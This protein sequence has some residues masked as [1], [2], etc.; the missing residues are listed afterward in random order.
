[1][2]SPTSL[3]RL[4]RR[5]GHAASGSATTTRTLSFN[6]HSER[7]RDA[8]YRSMLE[9]IER[10]RVARAQIERKEANRAW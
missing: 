5:R 6:P 1:M 4:R 9:A 8:V 2:T 10:H 3:S 7:G